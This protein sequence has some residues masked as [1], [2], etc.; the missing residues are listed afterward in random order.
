MNHIVAHFSSTRYTNKIIGGLSILLLSACAT[1]KPQSNIAE[2]TENKSKTPVHT[3]YIAGGLGNAENGSNPEIESLLKTHLAKADKQSTLLYVGDYTSKELNKDAN[4]AL[5]DKQLGLAENFKGETLFVPGNNEWE[6][7]NTDEIEWVED[8]LK[9]KNNKNIRVAPNN[10][11]PL[12]YI[13]VNKTLDMVLI[14]SQWFDTNWDSVEGI[15]KKCT[16]INTKRRFVEELEGY[17]KDSR[18]KNLLIVVHHPIFSNG[19]Y[20]G[21]D[22]FLESITPLPIVSNIIDEVSELGSFSNQQLRSQRYNYLCTTVSALAQESDRVTIVSGHEESLQYLTG[23]NI[24]QIVSGSLGGKTATR[25]TKGSIA[26]IGGTLDYEGKFTYGEEGFAIL[27]YFEDGSSEVQFIT[28]DS[29]N[30]FAVLN[31]F[32]E[33]KPD[34]KT[35]DFSEATK[36]V[37]ITTDEEKLDKSGFYKFI[38]GKRYRSYFGTPVT[39]EI[40]IL[41]TLYSGLKITKEGGGHQ[42]FSARL[43]DAND[44][45]YAMRGLEKNALKFLRFK[46]KGISYNEEEFKGTFIEKAVYDFFSTTHPYMQ[47]VINPLAKSAA[48]NHANTQLYYLPKQPGFRLLGDNY[49]DQLYFIEER[50]NDEQ[51]NFEGYNRANPQD[52]GEIKQ[53]ESTTDVL[54]KLNEDEKYSIDQRAYIRARI[55]DMLIGDW[56]RHE[57]QWRWAEYKVSDDDIRFIPIPRDRD[58][59][60]SKFD[61]IAIPLIK[62]IMPDVRFWQSYGPDIK[63]VKWF[64]GE[65]NN[66][67]KAF[68][69]KYDASVWEE[70][71]KF[72]QQNMTDAIIEDAFNRLPKEVQDE[73]SENIKQNLKARLGNI[74]KIAKRYGERINETVII[75]GTHKDDKIEIT[76]LA[77]GE[78]K[79]VLKRLLKDRPNKVFFERT[80]NRDE[81]NEIWIYGLNDDDEFEVS[82][83]GDREIM[84]RL[85]GGYGDDTF[86]IS[87]RRKLKV[88]DWQHEKAEFEDKTPAKQFTDLYETNT[89]FWRNFNENNNILL[90]NFGFRTDDGLFLGASDTYTNKGFNGEDF[91][92][93]H[94]LSANYYFD[95][96]A[97]E[98]AYKGTF[99]NIMPNWNLEAEG[100]FTSELFATNFFGYGNESVYDED[101][102]EMEF[103]RARIGQIKLSAGLAR[104]TIKLQALYERFEVEMQPDRFFTPVNVNPAVFSDQSYVGAE[105]SVRYKN[106]DAADFPTRGLEFDVTLGYKSNIE[107][108]DNNFGYASFLLGIDRRLVSSGNLVIGSEAEI[109]T[110]F[111][112]DYFFYHA[113]SLGGNNGLRGY[114]DERFAGQTSFYQSTDLKWRVARIITGVAPITIALYGGFDYG[115]VWV[116]NDTSNTWHTSQGGGIIFGALNS[117]GIKAGYF[118]SDEDA[119][120]QVGFDI[121]F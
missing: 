111:G 117:F 55:F 1:Y 115:R 92:Y 75:H 5:I 27:K 99:A 16:D 53:F 89:Y 84:I 42:S 57:D 85:V 87:N 19:K 94:Y 26:N 101:V 118:V 81:T 102:V 18:G 3:F 119:I 48:I 76:R 43:A 73:A 4:K 107:L 54:E 44:K 36:T 110:N 46:V 50:P 31:R 30:S 120:L 114:R 80:F 2:V 70:E 38:W 10:V 22:T 45:E 65:G 78:T 35:P 7:K 34:F 33:E 68:L 8:Y 69:N 29:E 13:E 74:D 41:D 103:N 116:E 71:A 20:A 105:G 21:K 17:I 32:P 121:G 40:A 83:E 56:D 90:P 95:F 106:Q 108:E 60:F 96:Q 100:Y 6:S 39:A 59:A 25:R 61:G 52:E 67:D 66:L 109:K 49:G 77:N 86:K 58:A 28:T 72:I 23:K 64:N 97:A 63:D 24:R 14:D 93:K 12:E 82:G 104:R 62:M 47:L 113:P 112:N 91:R 15:N 37:P 9:D 88:Y 11:C 79:V 51:R 98:I